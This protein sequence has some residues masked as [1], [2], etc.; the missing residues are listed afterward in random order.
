MVDHRGTN[1]SSSKV[2]MQLQ[3]GDPRRLVTQ[4]SFRSDILPKLLRDAKAFA[5][6]AA[7]PILANA[8]KAAKASFKAEVDRLTDLALRNPQVSPD[9]IRVLESTRDDS[10]AAL[11]SSRLRLDS[12]RVIWR[13]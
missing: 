6:E 10:L 7:K 9:E 1:L 8:K 11:K 12:I 5:D 3:K 13:T 4:P 2:K